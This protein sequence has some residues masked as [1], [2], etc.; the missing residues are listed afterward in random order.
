MRTFFSKT[1]IEH[2]AS[3]DETYF[4]HMAFAAGFSFRLFRAAFAALLHAFVPSLC[5]RTASNEIKAMHARIHNRG[6]A[7]DLAE[8][9]A[10]A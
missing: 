3:V 2:P 1:F 8:I 9:K 7:S 5:E 6:T 4:E 10:K